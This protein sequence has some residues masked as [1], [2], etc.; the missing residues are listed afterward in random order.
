MITATRIPSGRTRS[1]F[2]NSHTTEEV[3][4]LF[5]LLTSPENL[6]ADGERGPTQATVLYDRHR[7]DAD[8]R[9]NEIDA[10][11]QEAGHR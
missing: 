11:N 8:Q 3:R 10:H 5:A 4:D 2:A 7:A 1:A 6:G 9:I